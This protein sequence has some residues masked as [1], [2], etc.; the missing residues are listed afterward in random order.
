MNIPHTAADVLDNHVTLEYESIDR[1]YLNLY[2]PQLQSVGGVVGYLH[3]HHGQRFAST[4]AL[5]PK[6]KAFSKWVKH[7]AKRESIDI[8]RFR[9]G[10]RK[11]EVTQEYLS[12]FQGAEGVLYIGVAQEKARVMRT[13][14]RRNRNTGHT[15]PWVVAATAMVNYFYFYCVDTDAGPFFIKFRSYFPYNGKLCLND[16]EYARRQLRNHGIEF[17]PLDNG[18]RSC[19]DPAALN[20]L[21]AGFDSAVIHALTHKWFERLPHPYTAEARNAGLRYDISI[22]Q[23]EFN[24]TQVL[25]RPFAGRVLLKDVIRE[26]LD[27]GRPSQVQLIFDRRATKRTPGRFRTRVITNSVT[28]SLHVDYK[29]SRI[30]QYHKEGQ[31]LRTET[32]IND[33]D[34][35]ALGRRLPHLATLCQV[36]FAANRRW[37]ASTK[38]QS[39]L[40]LG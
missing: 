26:N 12:R 23:A 11:D 2:V 20:R 8:V 19:G 3:K 33:T 27:L 36:G 15:Y 9:K 25:D 6:S 7:F 37:F 30:K 13:Q 21:C 18:V 17:E 4:V 14:R 28:P 34:D 29:H 40:C 39:R 31:A 24:L 35:S 10:Q 22:L 38:D 16:N 5:A 32:T 1:M